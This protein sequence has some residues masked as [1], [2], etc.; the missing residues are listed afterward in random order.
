MVRHLPLQDLLLITLETDQY[1][2]STLEHHFSLP[3][4]PKDIL[5]PTS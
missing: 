3:I 5:H 1:D 2:D 4:L